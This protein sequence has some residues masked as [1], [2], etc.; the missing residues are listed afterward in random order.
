[1]MTTRHIGPALQPPAL[2]PEAPKLEA[3][4]SNLGR[5]TLEARCGHDAARGH[6]SRGT[7]RKGIIAVIGYAKRASLSEKA[8]ERAA[9]SL[10]RSTNRSAPQCI[11]LTHRRSTAGARIRLLVRLRGNDF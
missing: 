8:W 9:G 5:L 2:K 3:G 4:P 7:V 11:F 10:T 6:R 1:M